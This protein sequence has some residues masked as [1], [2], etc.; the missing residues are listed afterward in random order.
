MSAPE[1]RGRGRP[2][3]SG[4]T[5]ERRQITIPPSIEAIYRRFDGESLSGG[6][7]KAAP[8]IERLMRRRNAK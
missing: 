1:K 5:G 4:E 8:H 6:I 2:S 3:L 7:I